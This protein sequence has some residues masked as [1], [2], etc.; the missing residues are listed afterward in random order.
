MTCHYELN[1][2][3]AVKLILHLTKITPRF[4]LWFTRMP[5]INDGVSVE[6]QQ[7]IAI[8]RGTRR[9][10]VEPYLSLNGWECCNY[11]IVL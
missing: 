11:L 6:M 8:A 5:F 3:I 9:D 4:D 7:Y 10:E 2:D 1:N